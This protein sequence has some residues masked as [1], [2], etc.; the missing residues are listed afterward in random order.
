MYTER[1]MG[2]PTEEDNLAGYQAGDVTLL[3]EKLRGKSVYIM[4]GNADDN[5]HYQNAAKLYKKLQELDIPF[6][7][8]VS[9][10]GKYGDW[11]NT[12]IYFKLT[13][14]LH[15][16]WM[17]KSVYYLYEKKLKLIFSSSLKSWMIFMWCDSLYR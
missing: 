11:T 16:F 10:N 6:E 7:Q 15:I 5:V 1:Y 4:H 3:A 14:N 12:Q 13:L 17:L 8:M 9:W 2:L